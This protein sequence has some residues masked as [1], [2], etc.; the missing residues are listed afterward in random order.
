MFL[1]KKKTK[2]KRIVDFLNKKTKKNNNR[3]FAFLINKTKN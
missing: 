3:I 2:N 1:T